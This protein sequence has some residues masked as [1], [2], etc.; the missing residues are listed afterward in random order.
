MV[1]LTGWIASKAGG[2]GVEV[3]AHFAPSTV[4]DETVVI[5]GGHLTEA[6]IC[7]IKCV[8][9]ILMIEADSFHANQDE[10]TKSFDLSFRP[11]SRW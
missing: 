6:T 8:M 11:Q 5:M 7:G 1:S 9:A 4:Q 10:K 3:H 2:G